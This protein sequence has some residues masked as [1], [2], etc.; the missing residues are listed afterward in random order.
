MQTVPLPIFNP[1]YRNVDETEVTDASYLL[2]DA[3][4]DEAGGS[5]RRPGL[6]QL[7][8]HG[9]GVNNEIDGL[10]W[11][12]QKTVAISACGGNLYKL[13]YDAGTGVLSDTALSGDTLGSDTRVIWAADDTRVYAANGANIVHATTSSGSATTMADGD[14]P[15]SVTHIAWI[16]GYLL[17]NN[18]DENKVY[19]SDVNNPLSWTAGDYFSAVGNSDF[20]TAI[21]VF[22]REIYVFGPNSIE[23]WVNDGI[24]PFSRVPGGFI[25]TGVIAPYSI[26][27]TENGLFWLNNNRR[28][29]EFNGR[30]VK[31]ISTAYDKEIQGYSN[32]SDCMGNRIEIAGKPFLVFHFPGED[33]T[34]VY[35]YEAGDW[36][37]WR[38]YVGPSQTY[39]RWL[40]NDHIFAP[41]WGLHLV[42]DRSDSLVHNFSPEFLDD[43]GAEIRSARRTGHIS[44]GTSKTKR[45]DEIRF[46]VKRG[47]GDLTSRTPQM[48]IRWRNDNGPWGPE[49]FVDLGD[50]GEMGFIKRIQRTG[51]YRKRQY[52]FMCSDPAPFIFSDAEE[53][54][55]VLSR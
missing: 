33:K 47:T 48:T 20:V 35:N 6:S 21:H 51:M 17:A 5:T 55:V 18:V 9:L 45:S 23:T 4:L 36:A 29:V 25:E 1:V 28:F 52:E 41:N 54:I 34:L 14:A 12:P 38:Y 15:T 43:N 16:D 32:V 3:Y 10:F 26:V 7:L 8:D 44:Y 22:N 19:F 13:E 39:N 40:G 30:T 49:V 53:D 42:G 31:T 2:V 46:T 27:N 37:E 50:I 11:W 24:N